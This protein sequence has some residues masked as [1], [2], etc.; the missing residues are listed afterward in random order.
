MSEFLVQGESLTAIANAI[1][2]NTGGTE[3]LTLDDMVTAIS[4]SSGGGFCLQVVGGTECPDNATQGMIWA[5]TPNDIT[6][7]ALADTKPENPVEGMLYLKIVDSGNIEIPSPV[8]DDWVTVCPLSAEQYISG[9]WDTIEAVSYQ[10]GVWVDWF[11]YL[12]K[13]GNEYVDITGGWSANNVAVSSGVSVNT[14]SITKN[15]SDI[16]LQQT[17]SK[18]GACFSTTNAI[19]VTDYKTLCFDVAFKMENTTA[20][21]G[22][23]AVHSTRDTPRGT[24]EKFVEANTDGDIVSLDISALSGKHY[25]TIGLY[26]TSILTVR[27]VW[28]V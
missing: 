11:V 21:W 23:F 14:L 18:C 8:G 9:T 25:L 4:E 24:V 13:E 26:H 6:V 20:A 28:L 19:D 2:A 15:T 12:Y 22:L 16:V 1:R 27:K 3:L 10:D 5:N 17:V 7:V